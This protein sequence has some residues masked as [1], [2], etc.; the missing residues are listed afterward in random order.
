M[1]KGIAKL[2]V[3]RD[4]TAAPTTADVSVDTDVPLPDDKSGKRQAGFMQQ[5]RELEVGKVIY[6]G[7]QVNTR[8]PLDMLQLE[9]AQI[10]NKYRE[11][12]RTGIRR[13]HEEAPERIFDMTALDARSISGSGDSVAH[14]VI[15]I[16]R[17]A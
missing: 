15:A 2:R 7:K 11:S 6:V 16:T 3:L 4:K 9:I 12:A 8:C 1:A 13:M 5:L 17:V 14:V 10:A